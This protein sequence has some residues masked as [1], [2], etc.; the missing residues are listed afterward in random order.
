MEINAWVVLISNSCF[1]LDCLFFFLFSFLFFFFFFF[2]IVNANLKLEL[3]GWTGGSEHF[4]YSVKGHA[5]QLNHKLGSGWGRKGIKIVYVLPA[6]S[7]GLTALKFARIF[8]ASAVLLLAA[9]WTFVNYYLSTI[10]ILV[11]YKSAFMLE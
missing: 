5:L 1:L 10:W 3:W 7:T 11:C 2:L 8:S 9:C 6:H 4:N